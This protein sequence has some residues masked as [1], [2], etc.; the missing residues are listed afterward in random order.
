MARK[1]SNHDEGEQNEM[2]MKYLEE[3]KKKI[4]LNV[5]HY[6]IS[7]SSMRS[8]TSEDMHEAQPYEEESPVDALKKVED[9]LAKL[10]DKIKYIQNEF[11]NEKWN[12][13]KS[14]IFD[15]Y[16]KEDLNNIS[17]EFYETCGLHNH[18][19]FFVPWFITTYL[20]LFV[21]VL[22]RSY[23]DESGNIIQS[24]YPAQAP[25]ILPNNTV[26][27]FTAFHKFI[28]NEVAAGSINEINRL[29]S[30][31][32]YLGLYVKVIG[33][34]I[35]FLG[36]KL[37]SLSN[38][39]VQ[40]DNKLKSVKQDFILRPLHD[41]DN[42]LGKKFSQ[43][44]A[45]AKPI[46][47]AEDFADEMEATFD[48]KTQME[49]EVNKLHGYP[50]KK[51]GNTAYARKPSM[52]TYYYP[53]PTPQDVLIDERDWNQTNTSYSESEIDEWNFD[54]LTDRQ[55]T[56]MV[57]RMLMYATICKSVSNTDKT[58]CKM[59]IAGFTG[60]LRGWWDNYMPSDARAAVINAKAVN[61]GVDNLGFS[62]VQN[63]EDTVY[64]LILTILEHFSG[65]FTNQYE[66]IGSL[67][68]GLRC[69]HLD[70]V[71]K[72]LTNP[73]GIIPYNDFTYGKLIGACT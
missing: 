33:E 12:R 6:A 1:K 18:I 68:N 27:I 17:Q 13:F 14:W 66:I 5:S 34:H 30:Q 4:L 49:M 20:P 26:T 31:N 58:I 50:K 24:I 36:K 23:K 59:I 19:M 46:S 70:R 29:I 47:L 67:L 45:S 57:H 25:F 38:L 71:K 69:R 41:L 40:I 3:V 63:R 8:E 53:R 42:L 43:F 32:N 55:L 65:R 62:L 21:N 37:D 51:S 72:T 73:Q 60:Q 52:Q 15:T 54:G 2:I 10:K 11:L 64:T 28:D 56:I 16:N 22:E 7:D 44:G 9:F 35:C 39:I 48:F 61:E